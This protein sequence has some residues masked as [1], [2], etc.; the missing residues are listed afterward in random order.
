M[1][2][3]ANLNN[4]KQSEEVFKGN[5]R[6]W[7]ANEAMIKLALG[8]IEITGKE[9]I[10]KIPP[11]AKV[12]VMTT[13]L[14]DLDVPV[15]IH[16]IAK[17][18]DIAVMNMSVHHKFSEEAS[19]NIGMRIAGKD[20]FIPIDYKKDKAGAGGK[21]SGAF[22][23]NNFNPA[24]EATKKGKAILIAVHNPLA[25]PAKNLDNVK[26]GYGGIYLAELEDAY[27]LPV[28]IVLDQEAGMYGDTINTLKKK[29]NASVV[30]GEPFKPEKINNIEHFSEL[31]KKREEGKILNNQEMI[32]FSQLTHAL[33]E[34]SQ[35][36][37]K[38][39]SDQISK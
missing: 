17:D 30:I 29:P 6:L 5:K 13:H 15:A 7:L 23:S 1:K 14:T 19:T 21:S 26:G 25:E 18:L 27:I 36:I 12:V 31:T 24:I 2:I 3:E 28:T 9:N 10:N 4:L 33:R 38:K 39:M 35:D 8:K 20:N 22:N 16:S 11:G 37:I 34:K 32:E